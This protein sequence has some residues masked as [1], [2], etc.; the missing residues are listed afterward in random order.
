LRVP[1][2]EVSVYNVYITNQFKT[3]CSRGGVKSVRRGDFELQG[4]KIFNTF[5][6]GYVQE[7]GLWRDQLEGGDDMK[8]QLPLLFPLPFNRYTYHY[9][10]PGLGRTKEVRKL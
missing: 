9:L 10:S 3:T 2:L 7:F 1:K 5:F 4:G 6:P 8:L